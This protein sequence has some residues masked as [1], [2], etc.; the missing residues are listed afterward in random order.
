MNTLHERTGKKKI[1]I[2][3]FNLL[4]HYLRCLELADRYSKD[5][6]EILFLHSDE[7]A[8]FVKVQNYNT[9][10]CEQFHSAYAMECSGKFS[11]KWLNEKDIELIYLSQLSAIN[12]LKPDLVIGDVAPCLKMAAESAGVKYVAVMNGYMT[13]FY[14]FTR[15]LS[16]THKAYGFLRLLPPEVA[17]KITGFAERQALMRVHR[18]FNKLRV[19]YKLKKVEDYL[20]EIEGDQNLICD[21]PELFPQENLPANYRFIPPLIYKNAMP[22]GEWLS[23]LDK[24]KPVICVCMGSTGNWEALRFLNHHQYADY[25]I[26][27][28]GD[29]DKVLQGEHIIAREFINLNEVLEHSDLMI[30]HGGNGTI[31]FGLTKGVFMLCLT[32]HFEQEWN[33]QALERL[34]YGKSADRWKET[35]WER[36]IR[37][38]FQKAVLFSDRHHQ[39]I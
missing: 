10:H 29:S 34:G 5:E 22:E 20:F 33:V 36:G 37:L 17:D 9:F 27:T 11:F 32:S 6:Y 3:P 26:I 21:L 2:F 8:G 28:A 15:K 38:N 39:S 1:L 18:P 35:E 14:S 24:N 31:Y 23:R 16:R 12:H 30:C 19:R 4:S 25:T 7:Y 13:R